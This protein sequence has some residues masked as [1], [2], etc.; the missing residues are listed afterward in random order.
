MMNAN[1]TPYCIN[2]SIANRPREVV[3]PS[4]LGL[5]RLHLETPFSFR[6]T[7]RN[8]PCLILQRKSFGEPQQQPP[9]THEFTKKTEP[10]IS[11]SGDY[12]QQIGIHRGTLPLRP[13]AWHLREHLQLGQTQATR[14]PGCILR[15]ASDTLRQLHTDLRV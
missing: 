3:N 2:R 12:C 15:H 1:S 9:N 5:A 6:P 4:H 10:N 8:E 13:Y 11:C 7:E 14:L